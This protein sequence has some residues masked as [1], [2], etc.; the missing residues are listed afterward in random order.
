[1]SGLLFVVFGV[2][3][4]VALGLLA[5]IPLVFGFAIVLSKPASGMLL[6][7]WATAGLFGARTMLQ[8]WSGTYT[9]NTTLGLLAGI[10][11]ASPLTVPI[12]LDGHV[13]SSFAWL[14]FTVSPV[15]VAAGLLADRLLFRL[16]GDARIAEYEDA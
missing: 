3:P 4:V 14:Y 12:L 16:D 15:I 5:F 7:V 2:L 9:E 10:A 13:S 6:I 11:A 1:M 8:I